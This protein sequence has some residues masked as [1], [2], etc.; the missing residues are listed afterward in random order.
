MYQVLHP[1]PHPHES[2]FC[3]VGATEGC[4]GSNK[5]FLGV[6]NPSRPSPRVP[7]HIYHFYNVLHPLPR[8]Q[9]LT[10]GTPGDC[11]DGFSIS[12]NPEI[13][14]SH[15]S[16]AP[17]GQRLDSKGVAV[18]GAHGTRGTRGKGHV[19]HLGMV[20]MDSADPNTPNLTPHTLL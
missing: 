9:N 10:H 18:G 15:P 19:G 8:P 11:L 17:T 3:P 1:L 5:G 20:L 7:V 13:D 2:N 16:V 6:L 12:K 14:P 4:E